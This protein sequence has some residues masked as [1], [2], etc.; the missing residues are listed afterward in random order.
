MFQ[1]ATP[2][3]DKTY[4]GQAVT[5]DNF[6]PSYDIYKH[7]DGV[8]LRY[9]IPACYILPFVIVLVLI[10]IIV[11]I[12]VC[13]ICRG[14]EGYFRSNY[15]NKALKA[16][17]SEVRLQA[18][19]TAVVLVCSL[20]TIFVS[21]LDFLSLSLDNGTDLPSYYRPNSNPFFG[22][23][24]AFAIMSALSLICGAIGFVIVCIVWT[25]LIARARV[26]VYRFRHVAIPEHVV[27]Q[28]HA[29]VAQANAGPVAVAE[30]GEADGHGDADDQR[31][32]IKIGLLVCMVLCIGSTI[33]S[34]SFHFQ[35]ILIAWST[36]QFYASKIAFFYGIVIFTYFLAF[37]YAYSV[38]IT[39]K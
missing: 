7:F 12:L 14:D 4:I 34:L 3:V 39:L 18:N 17:M 5:G 24:I 20:F 1:T 38:P 19:T 13:I 30:Y 10:V 23:T 22:I 37:K 31:V 33:L 36:T 25:D 26:W 11:I 16:L 15:Y 8:Q 27:I 21:I 29:V 35:N 28:N 6:V 9:L 32:K 2:R